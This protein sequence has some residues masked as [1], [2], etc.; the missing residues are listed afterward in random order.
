MTGRPRILDYKILGKLATKLGKNIDGVRKNIDAMARRKRISSEAALV[1]SAEKYHIG[2][3]TYQR[4]LDPRIQDQISNARLT[5]S[6]SP[7][8]PRAIRG[9]MLKAKKNVGAH[10]DFSDPYLPAALYAGLDIVSSEAYPILFILENSL[11]AFIGRVLSGKYSSGWWLEVG[12][13]KSTK[14]IAKK[15]AD[16]KANESE[17]WHHA[18]RGVHEVY[19]IDYSDLLTIIRTFDAEFSVYFKKGAEK[20]LP[21]KLQ[22]LTPT[23]NVVAHNNPITKNDLDRLRIHA[24]DWVGYMQYLHGQNRP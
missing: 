3:A 24:R 14:D 6:P 9:K 1:L 5:V 23:R 16:R 15:A 2:T 11:R 13:K 10:P 20:N 4:K 8:T 19:Y 22:E 17:N 12:K 18:K 21:G 7:A